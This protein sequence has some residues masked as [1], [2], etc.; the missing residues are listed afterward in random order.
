MKDTKKHPMDKLHP[1]PHVR[2]ARGYRFPPGTDYSF[3][4]DCQHVWDDGGKLWKENRAV[5]YV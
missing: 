3:C 5:D 2:I 4:V 1:C